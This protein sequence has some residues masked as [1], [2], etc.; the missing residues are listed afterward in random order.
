MSEERQRTEIPKMDSVFVTEY[1]A[2]EYD[3]NS[4]F[5]EKCDCDP[6]AQE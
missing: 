2:K 6:Q 1:V 5:K 4:N 3:S